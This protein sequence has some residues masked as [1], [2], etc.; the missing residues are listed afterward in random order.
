MKK[1][2]AFLLV[3]MMFILCT[4]PAF[5]SSAIAP[6]TSDELILCDYWISKNSE[7]RP[8]GENRTPDDVFIADIDN[9]KAPELVVFYSYLGPGG[10]AVAIYKAVNGTV[11]QHGEITTDSGTGINHELCLSMEDNGDIKLIDH[12]SSYN[13]DT[14]C[15]QSILKMSYGAKGL[16]AEDYAEVQYID[17]VSYT[18]DITGAD[19]ISC[20]KD[21]ADA[22]FADSFAKMHQNIVFSSESDKKQSNDFFGLWTKQNEK[23]NGITVLIDGKKIEFDQKPVI[24]ENRTLVPLRAIFEEL[25]AAVIWDAET[26]T[27]ISV[28]DDTAVSVT[29]GKNTLVKNGEVIELDVAPRIIGSRTL[30]PV[31][32]VAESFD[33]KVEWEAETKTVIITTK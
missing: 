17:S 28:K 15:V 4:V 26:R 3:V 16:T 32:A 13:S 14:L 30:V 29:E 33:C 7:I 12:Y 6:Q 22:F 23:R 8:F 10:P 5:A 18:K 1:S 25:G 11:V 27:A 20:T 24:V 9:D 21:E 2:V 19:R 31:R